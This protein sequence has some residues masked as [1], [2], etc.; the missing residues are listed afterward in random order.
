MRFFFLN[1]WKNEGEELSQNFKGLGPF[2]AVFKTALKFLL[3]YRAAKA[4]LAP[5]QT[6]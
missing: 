3:H 1:K 5:Q 6:E 2:A 4:S